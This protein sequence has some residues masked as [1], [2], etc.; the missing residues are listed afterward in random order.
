MKGKVAPL[1]K[2]F[3]PQYYTIEEYP[4]SCCAPFCKVADKWG[5]FSNFGVTPLF[6]D[7]VEFSCVEKLFQCIKFYNNPEAVRDIFSASGQTIKMKAKKW[8]KAGATRAD[9]GQIIVDV[10][11][12]CLNL[13][14]NQVE[15]FRD[16]LLESKGM[17]IVEDQTT[18]RE[19]QANTWGCK[20]VG[21]KYVGPNLMGRLLMELRDDGL[22]S[23][24]PI[25][26]VSEIVEI[27]DSSN[28][29]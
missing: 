1:I 14:Y 15:A 19:K 20:L 28:N 22:F 16:A 26:K 24:N 3:Y 9:W 27:L 5:E 18:F 8:D 10:M 29:E 25:F 21:D 2:E 12:F 17:F 13:K 7:G 23:L 4:A 11:K 6:V